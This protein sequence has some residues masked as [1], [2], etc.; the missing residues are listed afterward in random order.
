MWSV[1]IA[2]AYGRKKLLSTK[3]IHSFAGRPLFYERDIHLF[4]FSCIAISL[5]VHCIWMCSNEAGDKFVTTRNRTT[6]H[7]DGK[8]S[9]WNKQFDMASTILMHWKFNGRNE[10]ELDGRSS[11]V[12]TLHSVSFTFVI[13]ASK[14]VM[15]NCSTQKKKNQKYKQVSWHIRKNAPPKAGDKCSGHKM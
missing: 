3:L 4:F 13:Y 5:Q 11:V 14:M 6:N 2:T 10:N 9:G 7:R 15:H 8:K 1:N 12:S